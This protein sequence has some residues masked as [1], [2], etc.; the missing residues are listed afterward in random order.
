MIRS[1]RELLVALCEVAMNWDAAL[2]IRRTQPYLSYLVLLHKLLIPAKQPKA[3]NKKIAAL[4]IL[5][6]PQQYEREKKH[7]AKYSQAQAKPRTPDI[8][9][10]GESTTRP[11]INFAILADFPTIVIYTL[12][13]IE[14][15]NSRL[16]SLLIA[17]TI[18]YLFTFALAV[19]L[20]E[21]INS[22]QYVIW[23]I[24][25]SWV[26]YLSWLVLF[27][28]FCWVPLSIFLMIQGFIL[29][30]RYKVEDFEG[31]RTVGNLSAFLPL[32]F[33]AIYIGTRVYSLVQ[34]IKSHQRRKTSSCPRNISIWGVD[35][36]YAKH[37]KS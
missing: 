4:K 36:R 15:E 14:E 8:T 17:T 19:F 27:L 31:D 24:Q 5:S 2:A 28:A 11:K 37:F 13:M 25:Y 3:M 35:S 34:F 16:K 18:A 21:F 29:R 33:F 9:P 26:I 32:V 22:D 7:P 30:N 23:S 1:H 6:C 20:S 12:Y 10:I